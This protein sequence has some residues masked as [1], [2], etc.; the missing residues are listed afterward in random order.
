MRQKY[1]IALDLGF[2]FSNLSFPSIMCVDS[3]NDDCKV[4]SL[5]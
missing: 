4:L 5:N 2:I 1:A 3:Q